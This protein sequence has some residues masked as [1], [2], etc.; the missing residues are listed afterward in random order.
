MRK[1]NFFLGPYSNR[2]KFLK[3]YGETDILTEPI[4]VDKLVNKLITNLL[5]DNLKILDPSCGR[6]PFLIKIYEYLFNYHYSDIDNVEERN[7]YCINSI[8]GCDIDERYVNVAIK[9]FE[10]I[11]TYYGVKNIIKPNIFKCDFLKQEFNMKFNVI[12]GNPPYQINSK[13]SNKR[14]EKL[15]TK[16]IEKSNDLLEDNGILSFITPTSWLSGSKNIRKGSFGVMDLFLDNNLIYIEKGFKFENVSIDTHYWIMKKDSNYTTTTVFDSKSNQVKI[17]NLRNGFFPSDL[18]NEK[19][20]II[21]KIFNMEPFDW[22]P[23]TS[24]YTKWRKDATDEETNS[25]TILTYVK[26]GNYENTQFAYFSKECKPEINSIKKVIIPLAGAEKFSPFIDIEGIPFCCDSYI[27]PLNENSTLESV[28]SIFYSKLYKFLVE[29][30]RSSGF[31][32]YPIIKRLPKLDT[33]KLWSNEEIYS[34]C[35]LNENEIQ[36]IESNVR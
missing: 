2:V 34:F 32:Q 9:E 15:W 21:E 31:V 3:P 7:Y 27:I 18:N 5:P 10:R 36:Y 24:M 11:Q 30:Y 1:N 23:A 17:L 35:S 25:N 16:F 29:N 22:I 20:S 12:L 28:S 6:G 13:K 33:T 26:G 8:S 19:T 4:Y 14:A